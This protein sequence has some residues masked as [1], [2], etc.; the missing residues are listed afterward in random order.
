[1][2]GEKI[3]TNLRIFSFSDLGDFPSSSAPSSGWLRWP[4]DTRL[5]LA[6]AKLGLV[7]LGDAAARALATPA[8]PLPDLATGPDAPLGWKFF[9]CSHGQELGQ[10]ADLASDW[11]LTRV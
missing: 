8:A 2:T 4:D 7:T 6:A 1:M 9:S 5:G 10:L 3:Q 11:L